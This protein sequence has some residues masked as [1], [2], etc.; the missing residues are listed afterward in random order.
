[1]PS[2]KT[3]VR[4]LLRRFDIDVVRYG[5][6]RKLLANA[7]AAHDIDFI[8]AMPENCVKQALD[9][10][11]HSQAQL[12]Q[13]V[14]VLCET[15]FKHGGF[16]VEFGATDGKTLSNSWLLEKDFGWT[17]IL[18][19]PGR[20]WHERLKAERSAAIEFD[21][22]WSNTGETMTFK[23]AEWAELSS[24]SLHSQGD[25]HA[26]SRASAR[27]YSIKTISLNDMLTRHGAPS[28]LDYLSIDTEGSEYEILQ[29]LDFDRYKFSII[30]CEHNFSD[31]RPQIHALLTSKGYVRKFEQ[32]SR[33]DDWYV[34]SDLS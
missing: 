20:I 29:A 8:R 30:T 19:E 24:L 5:Q 12:R 21:C 34:L 13:D 3:R 7:Y 15:G 32:V 25:Y 17:G 2:V 6:H 18:A 27:T 33:V 9:V 14:F 22:V 31:L 16:F 26:K 4:T 10:I 28:R 1:M 11:G 23:E